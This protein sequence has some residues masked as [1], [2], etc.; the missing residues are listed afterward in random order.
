MADTEQ[1]LKIYLKRFNN[2]REIKECIISYYAQKLL[3]EVQQVSIFAKH[4]IKNINLRMQGHDKQIN[5][6]L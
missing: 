6:D 4:T 2:L 3:Y 5:I 1:G